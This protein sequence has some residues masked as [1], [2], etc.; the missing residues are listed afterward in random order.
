MKKVLI[1]LV[2][3]L[4][5]SLAVILGGAYWG[6]Q[7][8]LGFGNSQLNVNE[9]GQELTVTRGMSLIA[10]G[11][12]LHEQG[13]IK[14]TWPLKVF[15]KLDPSKAHIRSGLYELSSNMTVNDLLNN[16]VNGKVK[17]FSVTLVEGQ[18]IKEWRAQLAKLP[19]LVVTEQMFDDV[20]AQHGDDSNLPEGKFFPDTYHYQAEENA[21]VLLNQG[22]LEMQANL[23]KA[24][25]GRAKNLPLKTPYELLILASIIEKET[26]QAGERDVISAVFINRLRKGMRLQTD[27]TVIY[28]MGDKFDGNIRRQD[29][30][31][32][33]PFN[34]YRIKG[35]PP[36]PIA[37]PGLASLMAAAHPANVDYLY[38]VSKNDGSHVFSKTLA[39]HNR[40]VNKYQRNRK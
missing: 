1:I 4:S 27:P 10:L 16:L 8:V 37:A 38:F 17:I 29:L 6:Y 30:L 34:T 19:H 36:T 21:K 33:T 11:N 25:Q 23:A 39:E 14:E 3:L 32:T 20:L 2:V 31:T 13:I 22:Y 15:V 28:G 7:Q 26:G 40:A 9:Q 18:T 5:I 24:W 35:L 12:K